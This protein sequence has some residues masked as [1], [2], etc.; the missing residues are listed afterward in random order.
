[1]RGPALA[2]AVTNGLGAWG[3][4]QAS[5]EAAGLLKRRER[6]AAPYPLVRQ[7]MASGTVVLWTYGLVEQ[8]AG[9]AAAASNAW[10]A[11]MLLDRNG[12]ARALLAKARHAY[13]DIGMRQH[14]ARV[15]IM[16]NELGI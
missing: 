3:V 12:A 1:L 11:R 2:H 8:T 9:I 10:Y 14:I 13:A 5:V 4:L 16:L 7:M 15:D 6:A